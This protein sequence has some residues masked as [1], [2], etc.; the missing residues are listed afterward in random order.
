[1]FCNIYQASLPSKKDTIATA[2]FYQDDK[3][4][5]SQA[6]AS[7]TDIVTQIKADKS[8]LSK[9]RKVNK[10]IVILL[11]KPNNSKR[12]KFL[13]FDW[14]FCST[15]LANSITHRKRNFTGCLARHRAVNLFCV[16]SRVRGTAWHCVA[17]HCTATDRVK[18]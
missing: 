1:M 14:K 11:K 16:P 8:D 9:D 17:L 6:A 18:R 13:R 3:S 10:M 4:F 12:I 2:V 7:S 5:P 15:T